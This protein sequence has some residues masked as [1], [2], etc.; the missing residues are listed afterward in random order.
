MRT[1]ELQDYQQC[2]RCI[3]DTTDP[4]ITFTASGICSHCTRYDALFRD[5]VEAAQAG[6]RDSQ[7]R[8]IVSH[9]K[10]RGKNRPYDC[11]VGV[12]GGVDSTFLLLRAVEFGL[13]PL[14]TH[15]DSGWNSELAVNNIERATSTLGVDLK[16]EVVDWNEM[17]DLQLSFIRAGVKNCDIP[18]DHAFPAVSLRNAAE[19]RIKYSLSG[20]N[21]ATESILPTAWGHNAADRR[22]LRAIQ[23]RHG[24]L[25]LKNYPTLGLVKKEIWYRYIRGIQTVKPLNYIPYVKSAAKQ[26]IADKVGWRDYGGKHHESVFTR[27]FQGHYLPRRFGYDKRLAHY[28]SLILSGQMTRDEALRSI[29]ESPPYDPDLQRSDAVFVAKKLG[30]SVTELDSLRDSPIDAVERYPTND[31]AYRLGF[32]ARALVHRQ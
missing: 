13:R 9:I 24:T 29:E 3:M 15:F 14:A 16:T 18:T 19:Y 7:L 6:R 25:K 8:E 30:I 22:Y 20:S 21:L 23:R 26:E 4:E 28:S 11:V 12:S 31:W 2:I 5:T 32:R 1:Q 10:E 17:R 27:Y